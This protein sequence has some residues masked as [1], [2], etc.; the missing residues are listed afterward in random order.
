MAGGAAVDWINGDPADLRRWRN[1]RPEV[2]NPVLPEGVAITDLRPAGGG[3]G[4][5]AFMPAA[6]AGTPVV[7]FH[8]GGFIVGSPETHRVNAAWI[9][10]LTGAP[11]FSIRY[12]LAPEHPLPA[13]A[14]D[15]VAALRRLFC[16]HPRLRLMG[17]SAGGLVALWA[18][19]GLGPEER[20]RIAGAVLFYPAGGPSVPR[21]P[22]LDD[23]EA[24]GLGPKSL[25]A[26]EARLDPNGIARGDPRYDPLA[27]GFACPSP[28]VIVG[29]GADPVLYQSEA[30]ARVAGAR[31]ILAAGEPHGFLAD[32]PAGPAIGWLRQALG[33]AP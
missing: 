23:D 19:A 6:P 8:G 24:D 25:A 21:P 20:A 9:A 33:G 1:A 22:G 2:V 31:L 4:G 26:Y 27:P 32:L 14:D 11:V 15:A 18:F 12:R 7:Y 29:A 3:P 13:Q 28:M 5:L 17:D 10:A 30:L 16:T